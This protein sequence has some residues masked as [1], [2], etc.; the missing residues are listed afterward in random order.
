MPELPE[1][2]TV[3]RTL[4]QL[5]KNKTITDVDV[6]WP[7]MIKEPDD[8]ERFIQLLKGQTIEDIGR[9]GKFLLFVLNDYV[10]VSHLRMEGR[11]G[12]YQPT[13]EKTKHT[14][15]VFSF[16]DGSELR[17]ADVRKFGTMH[18]F[19]KGAE[20][21]AMPLA[22]LGVEPFS[23][24]FTVELL[25]QAYAKTTRAIKT[26]LLDQKTVVGLGNIYVDEALFHAGIHPERTASSLSKEE[27]H[28][29]HKEIKRT[30]KEAIE[31]GGSSIKSY[32]NGQGE[33]GMFQQQLHVY[34]RK[35]QPCHHCDTAIEKTVVGG[36]GT[37]YCPNCQP[38]P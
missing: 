16:T 31:A 7:K 34:G 18:L 2:E 37:H 11:Y 9:R 4:L 23:E 30:L 22:Q 36:R 33:I 32:V 29:L 13:D 25:E 19:A 1:V 5:V 38:R 12:L 15:V 28:N 21:A 10:L 14:H 27:Y 26:A 8:V 17:Y 35:Q 24:Q 20:H 6:G 3:R